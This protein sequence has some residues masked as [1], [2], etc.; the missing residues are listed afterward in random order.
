M[1]TGY[2]Q[3]PISNFRT[4]FNE[5]VEPWL[6]PRDAF[7]V[8]V[9]A[10]LYRGV[11]EKVDGYR[12]FAKMSKRNVTQM[13]PA[14]NGINKTFTCTISPPQTTNF[15]GYGQIVTG[16][17]AEIFTY[18]DDG[19]YPIINLQGS[20][21]GT[22]TINLTTGLVTLNFFTAPP[23][24]VY[25]S[26]VFFESD[27]AKSASAIMGIKQYYSSDGNQ[28]QLI[29]D[30]SN[31]G[32]VK[33]VSGVISSNVGATQ[34]ITEVPH[35]YY[36][37]AVFTGGGGVVTF[38]TDGGG[39]NA[40]ILHG[41]I[42]P[43][44]IVFTQYTSTGVFVNSFT[45]NGQGGFTSAPAAS[46]SV[47]YI[48]GNYTITFSVA[49]TAGNYFDVT[50]GTFGSTFSG[51]ISNFFS[52]T[53]YQ[54]KAF[55]TNNK[56]PIFYYDGISIHYLK[57]NLSVKNVLS[58]SGV[59]SYDVSRCLHVFTYRERL[60]L[61]NYTV[62]TS[63]AVPN[64]IVWST[65]GDP[66]DFTND[67]NLPAPTSEPIRAIGYINTDLVNR[68]SNSERVFRYTGDAFSPFRWDSTNNIYPCDAPYSS[69]NY[70]SWFSTV[71]K[72]AIVGSDAVNVKRVDEIIPDFTDSSRLSLQVPVPW[73]N[74][75]SIQQGYG[76]RFDDIKEG[77]LCYNS[78]PDTQETV[79]ASD[80]VL[81]FNYLDQTY[82][83]YTFPFSCL[84]FGRTISVPTWSTTYTNW[85]DMNETWDSYQ[86]TENALVDLAGDQL[87]KV[88]QLNV[89][90]TLGDG[91]TPVLMNVIT[92][93]FN[94][95]IEQGEL[96]RFGYLDLFVS[97][98][99][100]TKLRVQFFLNDELY[101]D[102]SGN[103]QGYYK[104]TTIEFNPKD[105]M[106]P[107]QMQT[108]VWKRI[109]SGAVGKSHTIRLY[110]NLDDF[111]SEAL[112][113]PVWLHSMVLWMKPAGRL[114]N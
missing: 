46:G 58:S 28:Y 72:P 40:T 71:G 4:G 49:P 31:M 19:V 85:E 79:T 41:L 91:T 21:T 34:G 47:N 114:F 74:Q 1:T 106:S 30:Q 104:E 62:F 39:A 29:F 65:A 13:S 96:C 102:S 73:M 24:N 61:I 2:Q 88:Y 35:D 33:E 101:I 82:A 98:N 64:G 27:I 80:N 3:F 7:Q 14:P 97:A 11:V 54:Y 16:S 43:G 69:I 109:F 81:A 77:W 18:K 22:G 90:N 12:L 48:T 37:S 94:P 93:N 42:H 67:E 75:T 8:L 110:Q 89:G 112:D 63:Q 111:N 9:N 17:T 38:Y 57:T 26:D 103:P 107:T 76:E 36:Q 23:S 52:L 92:K 83:V 100:T 32:V 20:A 59:P 55:F 44:T 45:D 95:F 86:A 10:H 66:L 113:Q 5:S 78:A 99:Q 84:G 105:S 15:Y 6:L 87:G 50:T 70:D 108:K 53:N 68:F 60:L 56:D 51:T 25:A